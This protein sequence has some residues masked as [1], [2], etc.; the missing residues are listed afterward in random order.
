M[1]DK[2]NGTKRGLLNGKIGWIA[3]NA[4]FQTHSADFEEEARA[5]IA[6][7]KKNDEK[8]E[9]IVSMTR[10]DVVRVE[11]KVDGLHEDFE[12]LTARLDRVLALR[13]IQETAK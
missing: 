7:L 13:P 4:S 1:A 8:I 9:G 3:T 5:D 6:E 2:T 11:T 10:E 12:R